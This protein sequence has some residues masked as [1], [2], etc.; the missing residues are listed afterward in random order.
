[1]SNKSEII[2]FV[3]KRKSWNENT[4]KKPHYKSH[5]FR[6]VT[7]YNFHERADRAHVESIFSRVSFGEFFK[8]CIFVIQ[9]IYNIAYANFSKFYQ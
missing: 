1:M 5:A 8:L 2:F 9:Y 3:C 7:Q 6:V 4:I